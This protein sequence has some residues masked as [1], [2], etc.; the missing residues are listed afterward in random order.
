MVAQDM[1]FWLLHNIPSACQG[2]AAQAK[3]P[4][5]PLGDSIE[6]S[7][8]LFT[9]CQQSGSRHTHVATFGGCPAIW[10]STLALNKTRTYSMVPGRPAIPHTGP[11]PDEDL[12]YG[13][14][15]PCYRYTPHWPSTRRGPTLWGLAALQYPTLALN[16]MRTYSMVPGRPATGILHT[17]P[18][19]DEDLLYG[20]WPPCYTPQALNKTSTYSM[21]PGRPA[22]LHT[23]PQQDEYLLYRAW[24]PG[25]SVR[26]LEEMLE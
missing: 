9:T 14:W 12:L 11:Q 20:A 17:G 3:C 16:K 13:A 26:I 24:Q 10:Y 21:V 7:L 15:P 22:I 18:Q 23:G 8:N 4:S 19:Q 6:D 1:T 2:L 25:A 5:C